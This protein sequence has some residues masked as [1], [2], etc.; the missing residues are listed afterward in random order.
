MIVCNKIDA[1]K[2][3]DLSEENRSIINSALTD[4]VDL[5]FM[6]TYTGEGVA[7]VK[8]KVKLLQFTLTV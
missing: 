5:V 7:E 1:I 4:G 2:F 3:E 6:S 8:E